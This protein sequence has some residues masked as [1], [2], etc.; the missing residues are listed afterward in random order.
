MRFKKDIQLELIIAKDS[1][2]IAGT[3][4]EAEPT[5]TVVAKDGERKNGKIPSICK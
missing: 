2:F 5:T 3:A 1:N 4:A